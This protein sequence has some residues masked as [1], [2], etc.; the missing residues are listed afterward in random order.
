MR[1]RLLHFA[2]AG[3]RR[4]S[5]RDAGAPLAL[6]AL[7]LFAAAARPP[8]ARIM[9]SGQSVVEGNS[10]VTSFT[11]VVSLPFPLNTDMTASYSTADGTATLADND[12][13]QANGKFTI[14]AGKTDSPPIT[15]QVVGDTKIESDEFFTFIVHFS[16]P[17]FDPAPYVITIVNDDVPVVTVG[18]ARVTEGNAGLTP[19]PFDVTLTTPAAIPISVTFQ[20]FPI[21]AAEG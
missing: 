19:M 2:A 10:G 16:D 5:R 17:A 15:L 21:T 14:P 4:T 12:Y 6:A 1:R 18:D 11:V 13:V 8:A 3:R 9:A 20:T 7:L